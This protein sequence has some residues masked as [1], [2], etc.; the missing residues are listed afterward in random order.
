LAAKEEIVLDTTE[1]GVLC[2]VSTLYLLTRGFASAQNS[3]LNK[4]C[5]SPAVQ[6]QTPSWR[7]LVSGWTIPFSYRFYYS[8]NVV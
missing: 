4:N 3:A 6:L 5:D 2:I 1:R 7:A 8:P